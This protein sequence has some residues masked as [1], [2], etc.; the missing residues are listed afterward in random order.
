[1]IEY[2]ESSLKFLMYNATPAQEKS[3]ADIFVCREVKAKLANRPEASSTSDVPV[4]FPPGN[5]T[6]SL[7]ND[8]ALP[9]K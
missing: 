2:N 6:S 8:D 4:D 9:M 1:M 5:P 7:S 3:T